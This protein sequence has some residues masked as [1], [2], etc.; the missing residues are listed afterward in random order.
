MLSKMDILLAPLFAKEGEKRGHLPKK[1]RE[2]GI[3][4][5]RGDR[6]KIPTKGCIGW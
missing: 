4:L 3:F 6:G 1:G 5:K 2:G